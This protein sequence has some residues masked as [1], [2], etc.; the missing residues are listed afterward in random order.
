MY[1]IIM[2]LCVATLLSGCCG[3]YSKC[4]QPSNCGAGA[5]CG[6]GGDCATYKGCGCC[7][8]VTY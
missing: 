8:K 5:T 3:M 6:C 7:P 2:G 1:K 4:S